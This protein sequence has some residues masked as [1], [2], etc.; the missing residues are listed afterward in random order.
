MP[1]SP[2]EVAAIL[3]GSFAVLIVLRV[4]VAFALALAC[5]PVFFLSDRLS[6]PLLFDPMFVSYNS[7]ILLAVTFFLL[8]AHLLPSAGITQRL[9]AL[10]PVMVGHLPGGLGPIPVLV[11]LQFA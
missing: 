9:L 7:F 6:P 5:I 10:S 4:T 8:A 3:F 11:P 1:L 2:G